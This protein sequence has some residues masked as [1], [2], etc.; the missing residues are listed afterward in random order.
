MSTTTP[1]APTT[2]L[3]MSL[4]IEDL[5]VENREYFRFCSTHSFHLQACTACKLLRYTP[6]TACPWCGNPE[7]VWT[8]VEGRGAVHSYT[9]VRHVVQPGFKP[10]SPYLVLLVDLDVQK[11]VPT[12]DESI[13]VVGNLVDA[14]GTLAGP[15]LVKTVGIGTRVR[16]VFTDIEPGISI[17]QWTIDEQAVQPGN[18]WRFPQ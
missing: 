13:R 17:P 10:H 15:E 5:D 7:S 9:E 3:G 8:A 1:A 18:V 12:K 11:G 2:Y 4:S 16:M 14:Q 6:T